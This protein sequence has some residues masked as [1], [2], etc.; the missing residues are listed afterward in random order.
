[1]L[2]V[3]LYA[4]ILICRS[5]HISHRVSVVEEVLQDLAIGVEDLG[6]GHE[7]DVFAFVGDGQV[8]G[9][10][11]VKGAHHLVHRFV[12]VYHGWRGGHEPRYVH[13]PVQVRAEHDVADIIKQNHAFQIPLVV[14]YRI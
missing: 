3:I 4:Y 8:P 12:H 11:L 1:M 9:V 10:G 13:L 14:H 2:N 6:L 7:A 5:I